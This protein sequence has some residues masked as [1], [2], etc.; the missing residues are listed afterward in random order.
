M[1]FCAAGLKEEFAT[2]RD[3]VRRG[4]RREGGGQGGI[5]RAHGIAH[6]FA[7]RGKGRDFVGAAG[8]RHGHL[9]A[10]SAG[11][12]EGVDRARRNIEISGVADEQT[13]VGVKRVSINRSRQIART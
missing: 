6:P 7:Q 12:G 9:R 2:L 4:S 3:V 10:I 13:M 5:G 1:T 11:N 8:Q